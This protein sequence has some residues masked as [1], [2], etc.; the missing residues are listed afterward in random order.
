[1]LARIALSKAPRHV[2]AQR[3]ASSKAVKRS[4]GLVGLEVDPE[5][6]VKAI[7]VYKQTLAELQTLQSSF[8]NDI[9]AVTAYRLKVMEENAED[10]A[11]EELLQCGQIEEL[12][13]QAQGEL[14]LTR[15]L[16]ESQEKRE[17]A[18]I[19]EETAKAVKKEDHTL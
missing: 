13:Q 12:L 16:I 10:E 19:I 6:R 17:K 18:R 9:E 8:R 14:H 5:A 7:G 3:F 15:F 1:M 2:V 4:T 11:I